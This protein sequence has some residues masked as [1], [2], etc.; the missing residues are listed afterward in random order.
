MDILLI[1]TFLPDLHMLFR[2]KAGEECITYISTALLLPCK[3]SGEIY[4]AFNT[5]L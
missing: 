1:V 4:L 2:L 3:T 5:Q